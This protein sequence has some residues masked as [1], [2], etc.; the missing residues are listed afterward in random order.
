MID[1]FESLRIPWWAASL[2]WTWCGKAEEAVGKLGRST[3]L[4]SDESMLR[5][6]ETSSLSVAGSVATWLRDSCGCPELDRH[7]F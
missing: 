6:Y 4:R 5:G 2:G 7:E 1:T 3:R